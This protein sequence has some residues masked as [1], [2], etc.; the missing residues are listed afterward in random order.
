MQARV[1]EGRLVHYA[2]IVIPLRGVSSG[3]LLFGNVPVG[4]LLP[5]GPPLER[6]R[7]MIELLFEFGLEILPGTF[8]PAFHAR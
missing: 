1:A 4:V 8:G 6:H 7:K 3:N 2:R 5:L